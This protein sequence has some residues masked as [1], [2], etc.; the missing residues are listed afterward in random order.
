MDD[1]DK[2]VSFTP[3]HFRGI[4][5]ASPT[6]FAQCKAGVNNVGNFIAGEKTPEQEED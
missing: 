4:L 6:V 5:N 2:P 1:G 3:K